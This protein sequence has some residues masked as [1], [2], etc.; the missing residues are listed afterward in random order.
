[1]SRSAV[2]RDEWRTFRADRVAQILPTG[3]AVELL[4]PPDA[5]LLVSRSMA[6]GA[7]P[8]YVTVRLPLP[9]DQAL[10][11]VPPTVGTHRPDGTDATVVEIGGLDADG[12]AKYL[13]SLGTPLRVLSP[14]GV[15]E[16]L[17]GRTRELLAD[18]GSGPP[19]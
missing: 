13:L 18:N 5:A 8:L 16:A 19:R 17:L 14:D 6:R 12:L 2:A 7:Y 4:D 9:M 1:V 3:H 11:L 15:R 10:R